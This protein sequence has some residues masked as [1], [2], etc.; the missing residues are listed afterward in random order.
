[1]NGHHDRIAR[2]WQALTEGN[3]CFDRVCTSNDQMHNALVRVCYPLMRHSEGDEIRPRDCV[4]L[5]SGPRVIDLP[6]VAKVGS[7]WQTTEGDLMI[8]LLWYYR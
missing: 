3:I 6:F 2:S 1:M 5:K 4:L 7:L 8:S